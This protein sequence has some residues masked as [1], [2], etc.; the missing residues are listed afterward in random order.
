[1][2]LSQ[3]VVSGAN[4]LRLTVILALS[5][6]VELTE[7]LNLIDVLI[8]FLLELGHFEQKV[9]NLLAQLVALVGL[10][11]NIALQA[12]DIDLFAGDLIAS[13][14][15]VLLNIADNAALLIEK[16]S[17]V[18]HLLLESN[19]GHGVGVMLHP[20]LVVL[21]QLLILQV[22]VLRLDRVE[23]IAEG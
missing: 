15:Q 21:Q 12:G 1:M 11:C 10:L 19:D 14:P 9:I 2:S 13:C 7:S 6:G 3:L 18:V 17:Q 20:E 4:F 22:S 5:V 8:L 23:L 16:E